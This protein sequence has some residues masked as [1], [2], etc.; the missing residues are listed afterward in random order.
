MPPQS[1]SRSIARS[2]RPLRLLSLEL[3]H[4]ALNPCRTAPTLSWT[5]YL[6][7]KRAGLYFCS[8]KRLNTATDPR[9][10]TGAGSRCCSRVVSQP[11]ENSKRLDAAR[12]GGLKAYVLC[13][14]TDVK[15]EDS[16]FIGAAGGRHRYVARLPAATA[17]SRW[18]VDRD[19]KLPQ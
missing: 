6:E 14:C 16:C 4:G 12:A 11:R 13:G 19:T 15:E 3:V 9:D 10:W 18:V 8:I 1:P 5:D 2:P 17:S 7:K